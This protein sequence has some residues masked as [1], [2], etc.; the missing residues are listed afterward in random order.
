MMN[1]DLLH[2][3]GAAPRI[4]ITAEE[5]GPAGELILPDHYTGAVARAG[6]LPVPIAPWRTDDLALLAT[7]DGLILAG[8]GDIHPNRYG[9]PGHVAIH[10]VDPERDAG[11]YA[12]LAGAQARGLPVLGICRGAQLIN[13]ALGGTLHEH[14]PDVLSGAVQH[15]GEPP[16]FVPHPVQVSAGSLLAQLLGAQQVVPASWHHQAIDRIAPGLVAVA[17]ADDGC[18]EAVEWAAPGAV[19]GAAPGAQPWLA[20]VQWHPERTA[21]EDPVQQRLFAALVAA[22]RET[23]AVP[24]GNAALSSA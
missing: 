18:I 8:G 22:A 19:P 4:G 15:C 6:G 24:L 10:E 14:L 9:S 3:D 2:E 20:A 23:R 21:A 17:W 11:E 13:V 12:L 16:A 7:L 1:F 5:R